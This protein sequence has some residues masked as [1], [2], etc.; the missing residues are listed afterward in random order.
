MFRHQRF[1]LGFRALAVIAAG[2]A[3][4]S[5]ATPAAKA[6]DGPFPGLIGTWSGSGVAKFDG[7]KK[8]SLRCK[9]YYTNT[10][11]P[12][13]L[14]ISIRCANA[15]AKVELRA[16]LVDAG[17]AVSGSWEERTYNQS[18]SVTGRATANR[19]KLSI[20][21]GITGSMLVTV[22]HNSHSVAVLTSGPSLKGINISMTR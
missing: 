17:G 9:G 10:G 2:A 15:S 8:E 4:S 3:F 13:S 21:G 19:L 18:G 12:H 1:F 7:G 11:G 14:G 20:S 6:A 5:I 22:S 16:S